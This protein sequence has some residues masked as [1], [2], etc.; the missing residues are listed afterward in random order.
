MSEPPGGLEEAELGMWR[1]GLEDETQPRDDVV[2]A[3]LRE[4]NCSTQS[5]YQTQGSW[6]TFRSTSGHPRN[7]ALEEELQFEKSEGGP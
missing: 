3:N 6:T 2:C 1:V 4:Q 5:G 7:K